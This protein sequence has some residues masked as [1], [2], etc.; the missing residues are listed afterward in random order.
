MWLVGLPYASSASGSSGVPS[1]LPVI[2]LDNTLDSRY[3][4]LMDVEKIKNQIHR[5]LK[6]SSLRAL[7]LELEV[8]A[9]NLSQFLSDKRNFSSATLTK[10][11]E[12]LTNDPE[13]RKELLGTERKKLP[14]KKSSDE[15]SRLSEEEF[16]ELKEWY[17]F[18]VRTVLSLSTLK[19]DPKWIAEKLGIKPGEAEK[20]LKI[21]F[22]LNLIKLA[23]DGN[24]VRTKRH[25]LTPDST[26]PT[27][28][29]DAHKRKIH[30]QHIER[31]KSALELDPAKRDITWVNIP[32][33]PAKLERARELIRKF[34]DEMLEL[35]EDDETSELY[36]LT[37]QLVPMTNL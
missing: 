20:A 3:P 22:R 12:A 17:H 29:I 37:I 10:I 26:R 7:A 24:I 31:A 25:L 34:Q 19:P 18:A 27:P 8:P 11:V 35:L 21:L 1:F 5:R 14:V 36:R 30:T 2:G 33:N 13:E 6:K 9:G 15:A 28:K 32:T 4:D 16:L 23:P